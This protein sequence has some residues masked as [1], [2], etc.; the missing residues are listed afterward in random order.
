MGIMFDSK[1]PDGEPTGNQLFKAEARPRLVLWYEHVFVRLLSREHP[2]CRPDAIRVS[3][4]AVAF[5]NR[6]RV[7]GHG[8]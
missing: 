7:E 6:Q 3:M 5:P 1:N 8:V 4:I 2:R